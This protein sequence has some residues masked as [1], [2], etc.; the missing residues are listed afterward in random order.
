M[1][2]ATRERDTDRRYIDINRE[3]KRNNK[4]KIFLTTTREHEDI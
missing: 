4:N 1:R 2:A 3:R